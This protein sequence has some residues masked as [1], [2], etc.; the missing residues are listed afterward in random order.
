M[1]RIGADLANLKPTGEAYTPEEFVPV[2][3]NRPTRDYCKKS[4]RQLLGKPTYGKIDEVM[5]RVV[6][7]AIHTA[8]MTEAHVERVIAKILA[9]LPRWPDVTDIRQ[10]ALETRDIDLR[11]NPDC[12]KCG[13]CGFSAVQRTIKT[14][15]GPQIY[16]GSVK[17]D[18]WRYVKVEAQAL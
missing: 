6:I 18:C 13:G 14:V 1:R 8:C 3:P 10:V 2:A 16:P 4:V 11:P 12:G 17:C 9:E 7:D 15:L 5:I